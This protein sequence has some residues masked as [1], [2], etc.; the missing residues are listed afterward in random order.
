MGIAQKST[1]GTEIAVWDNGK[2]I[3]EIQAVTDRNTLTF[4]HDIHFGMNNPDFDTW[5]LA[6]PEKVMLPGLGPR[7]LDMKNR[8]GRVA[9]YSWM[10]EYYINFQLRRCDDALKGI[11]RDRKLPLPT[12]VQAQKNW[13]ATQ[14]ELKLTKTRLS[15]FGTDR[16]FRKWLRELF[17]EKPVTSFEFGPGAKKFEKVHG[18]PQCVSIEGRMKYLPGCKVKAD[19]AKLTQEQY[20]ALWSKAALEGALSKFK[21]TI[22]FHLD[23]MGNIRSILEKSDDATYSMTSRELRYVWRHWPDF[24][25]PARGPGGLAQIRFYNGYTKDGGDVVE[26]ECPWDN[27]SVIF[28]KLNA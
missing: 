28:R 17:K 23:G 10:F 27:S 21:S 6:A 3:P 26:V 14:E 8:G 19:I 9:E 5:H 15:G 25:G 4:E 7:S 11:Q 1:H 20:G 22:H 18:V 16:A 13:K 24:K 12:R 2:P